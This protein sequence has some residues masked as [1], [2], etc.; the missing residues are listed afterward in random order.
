L[1]RFDIFFKEYVETYIQAQD[2]FYEAPGRDK[3]I[4]D[5]THSNDSQER[6]VQPDTAG[7]DL[8]LLHPNKCCIEPELFVLVE[9]T[10]FSSCLRAKM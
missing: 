7:H 2:L 3:G 4:I 9:V 6:I 8:S 1:E 10:A 5:M